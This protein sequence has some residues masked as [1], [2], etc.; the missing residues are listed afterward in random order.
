MQES[1]CFRKEGGDMLT[2]RLN[3]RFEPAQMQELER[4]ANSRGLQPSSLAR[5]VLID[6][7]NLPTDAATNGRGQSVHDTKEPAGVSA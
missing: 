5:S 4:I 7:L 3:I 2:E 1:A 6:C